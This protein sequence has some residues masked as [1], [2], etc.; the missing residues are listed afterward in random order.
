[1][2]PC[3][4]CKQQPATVH[5]TEISD[6]QKRE[7]HLCAFCAQ[8]KGVHVQSDFSINE[9]LGE[10]VEA[11]VARR[12]KGGAVPKCPE[13][14]MTFAEFRSV[15]RLGCPNDYEVFR[16]ALEAFIE[17]V[18]GSAQHCGKS[19]DVGKEGRQRQK[20]LFRLRKELSEAVEQEAYE[21]AA[22]LRD[23]IRRLDVR[24]EE[25]EEGK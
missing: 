22:Q 12:V 18:H 15:G 13:C 4:I 19:P 2:I 20:E 11:P 9:I 5:L 1:M 25:R 6:N 16:E 21:Q 23:Q 3:E 10:L 8:K 14:G 17:K 7:A 24:G